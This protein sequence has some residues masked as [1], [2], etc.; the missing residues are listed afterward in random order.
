MASSQDKIDSAV[1]NGNARGADVS[2]AIKRAVPQVARRLPAFLGDQMAVAER[3]AAIAVGTIMDS[4]G[5]R[6]C[7]PASIVRGVIRAA[8]YGLALDG[9]LGHAYLVPYAVKGVKTAQF[10]IGYRGLVELMYR[11]G[12]WASIA[13][14]YGITALE[15]CQVAR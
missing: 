14:D 12:M 2:L 5:L 4:P 1:G 6:D 8:E 9:V 3:Y 7:T 11:T 10:Q 15:D 13:A